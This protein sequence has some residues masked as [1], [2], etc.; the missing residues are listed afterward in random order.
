MVLNRSQSKEETFREQRSHHEREEEK[1][2]QQKQQ[3]HVPD[4]EEESEPQKT[5]HVI[6]GVTYSSP[7]VFDDVALEDFRTI[8]N[9][10]RFRRHP[11][12]ADAESDFEA[13]DSY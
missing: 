5:M 6:G 7:V 8:T 2:Q 10:P 3:E 13:L 11:V 1:E 12:L 9:I 4:M